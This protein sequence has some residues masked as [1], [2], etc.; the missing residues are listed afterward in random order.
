MYISKNSIKVNKEKN[1]HTLVEVLVYVALIVIIAGALMSVLILNSRLFFQF[2]ITEQVTESAN[3][4]LGRLMH[5]I[6]ESISVGTSTS[7]FNTDPG[8]LSLVV[9]DVP[10]GTTTRRFYLENG[11]LMIQ[12]GSN[13]PGRLTPRSIAITHL[14]FRH[15]TTSS[16]TE[17]VRVEMSIQ[18]GTST[19]LITKNFYITATPRGGY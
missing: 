14:T 3:L 11:T 17:A 5:D 13:S 7:I 4:S 10:T 16:T 6:R 19:T 15:F 8:T 18:G 2:R 12:E 9:S 1:G